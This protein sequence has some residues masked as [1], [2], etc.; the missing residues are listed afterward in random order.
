MDHKSQIRITESG[1]VRSVSDIVKQIQEIR[2]HC[3]LE[4]IMNEIE[5]SIKHGILAWEA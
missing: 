4:D 2:I 5:Y 1:E 3:S